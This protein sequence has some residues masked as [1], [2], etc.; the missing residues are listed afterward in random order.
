MVLEGSGRAALLG[1]QAASCGEERPPRLGVFWVFTGDV[2]ALAE[3]TEQGK[4]V[5]FIS[6]SRISNSYL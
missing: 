4:K 6:V 1:A 5:L 3:G 2:A